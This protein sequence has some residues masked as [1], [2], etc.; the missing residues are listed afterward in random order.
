[1]RLNSY[2]QL[3]RSAVE[4]LIGRYRD[5][6]I[7][8]MT[9][10]AFCE[11]RFEPKAWNSIGVYMRG[12]GV[13]HSA[14]LLGVLGGSTDAQTSVSEAHAKWLAQSYGAWRGDFGMRCMKFEG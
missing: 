14:G 10:L 3:T 9:S 2:G 8:T 6:S 11:S 12:T 5:W 4:Y 1:M 13:E 7:P